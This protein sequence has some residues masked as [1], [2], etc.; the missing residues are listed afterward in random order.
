MKKGR[1]Q[2]NIV[3]QKKISHPKAIEDQTLDR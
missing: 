3:D 1:P 2:V